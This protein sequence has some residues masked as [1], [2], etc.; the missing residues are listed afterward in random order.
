MAVDE[1]ARIDEQLRRALEGEAWHGLSVLQA[2]EELG[3]LNQQLR[4]AV[5]AFLPERLDEPLIP[6]IASPPTISS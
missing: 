2:V 5:R 4:E 1:L 6:E 3:R